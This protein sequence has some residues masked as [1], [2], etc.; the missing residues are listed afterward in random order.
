MLHEI[1][2][3]SQHSGSGRTCVLRLHSPKLFWS[4]FNPVSIQ[5]DWQWNEHWVLYPLGQN[6]RK[7]L[8]MFQ[9]QLS[10]L[11]AGGDFHRGTPNKAMSHVPSIVGNVYNLALSLLLMLWSLV[12]NPNSWGQFRWCVLTKEF[13]EQVSCINLSPF[14][15][16]S[17]S[18][19]AVL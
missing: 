4:G 16:Y 15:S 5:G 10:I 12:R 9:N 14:C 1:Q 8:K 18:C 6:M 7:L 17:I 19:V 13:L 11:P 3:T 2:L